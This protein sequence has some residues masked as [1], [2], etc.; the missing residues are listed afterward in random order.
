[1]RLLWG[2][3]GGGRLAGLDPRVKLLWL[4]GNLALLVWSP[5]PWMPVLV[6]VLVWAANLAAGIGT[7]ALLPLAKAGAVV[8][9]QLALLQGVLHRQGPVWFKLGGVEVHAGGALLGLWGAALL[10]AMAALLLQFLMLTA[11]LELSLLLVRWR[12]PQRYA[13]VLGMALRFLPLLQKDLLDVME[14]QQARGLDLR[15]P[16]RKV[17][18]LLPVLLPLLLRTLRRSEAVALAMELKAFG[19]HKERTWPRDLR[20][21][22]ADLAALALVCAYLAAVACLA[23]WA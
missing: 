8:A 12:L 16:W 3:A 20:L 23:A 21:G 19:L 11:P 5:W 13:V 9:L 22:R 2:A 18:R 14:S 10:V 6:L 15:G 1:M 4:T 7:R 17:R